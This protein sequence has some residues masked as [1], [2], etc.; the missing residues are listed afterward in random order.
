VGVNRLVVITTGGTIASRADADG[1]MRP[2][3]SGADL[4]DGLDAEVVDLMSVDSSQLTPAHWDS[5][6]TAV[7][8]IAKRPEVEGVVI[9]HGTDTMEESALWLELTYDGATPVVITGALRSADAPN[10]DGPQ[11]LRD[12]LAVPPARWPTASVCW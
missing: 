12:A 9:T 11:N 5:M 10:A 8:A 7:A 6:R 2:S 3:T 1:V 4:V